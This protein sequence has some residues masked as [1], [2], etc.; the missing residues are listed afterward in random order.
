MGLVLHNLEECPPGY[1]RYKVPETGK[2]FPDPT[3]SNKYVSMGSLLT[4]LKNH[5]R[6]NA[7]P[8]PDNLSQ[9][10]QDQLCRFLPPERCH[11]ESP[12]DRPVPI[13]GRLTFDQLLQGT[14]SVIGWALNGRSK[15][16]ETE[17]D[18]RAATCVRCPM[19]V[20]PPGCP[21]CNSPL[22]T[23]LN[24]FVGNRPT[25]YDKA[26]NACA[27]CGCSLKVLVQM[28]IETVKEHLSQQQIDA[29]PDYCWQK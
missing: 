19:N 3:G 5:Y 4:D 29:L 16:S 11:Y 12:H 10:V 6:A 17:S 14:K 26:I 28:P 21:T 15:V 2:Q 25:R 7:L 18:N 8:V 13:L 1:F 24:S 9:L 22:R 20:T 23:L 27:V